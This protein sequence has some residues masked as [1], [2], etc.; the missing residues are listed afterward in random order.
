MRRLN[1]IQKSIRSVVASDGEPPELLAEIRSAVESI[2]DEARLELYR[3]M[4]AD[5]EVDPAMLDAPA[6]NE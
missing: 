5:L 6:V 1:R 4:A 3:W 2:D